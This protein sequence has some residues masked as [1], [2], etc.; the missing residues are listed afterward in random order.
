[1]LDPCGNEDCRR[2]GI[3]DVRVYIK[4]LDIHV[5]EKVC[6]YCKSDLTQNPDYEVVTL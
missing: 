6:A 5:E 4:D 1:M 2:I 3:H